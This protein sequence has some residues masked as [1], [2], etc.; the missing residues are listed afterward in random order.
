MLFYFYFF[1]HY[2]YYYYYFWVGGA[3]GE[4][5]DEDDIEL[6]G[7]RNVWVMS[8]VKVMEKPTEV[9]FIEPH[10]GE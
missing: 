2:H 10:Y 1:Y 3:G 7:K 9:S 5:K 4:K 6:W 8:D